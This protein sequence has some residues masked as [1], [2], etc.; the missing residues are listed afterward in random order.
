MHL[1]LLYTHFFFQIFNCTFNLEGS[2]LHRQYF[3]LKKL[4]I[5]FIRD[6]YT[7]EDEMVFIP[8]ISSS[9]TTS[10]YKTNINEHIQHNQ[11][12][13]VHVFSLHNT[14]LSSSTYSLHN[15]NKITPE[16]I[17]YFSTVDH[18]C[19]AEVLVNKFN[20]RKQQKKSIRNLR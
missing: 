4:K 8:S 20:R 12:R 1:P 9:S 6:Y 2:I 11:R 10:S 18:Y 3:F 14:Q 13:S 19:C 7:D 17:Q 15:N 5:L 16:E